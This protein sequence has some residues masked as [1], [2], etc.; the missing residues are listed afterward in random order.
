MLPFA[1]VLTIALEVSGVLK[2]DAPVSVETASI[3]LQ[4]EAL[5]STASQ[6]AGVVVRGADARMIDRLR[7]E[8]SDLKDKAVSDLVRKDSV[9]INRQAA[10]QLK[11]RR[12][13]LVTIVLPA[14]TLTPMGLTPKS[15]SYRV[16]AVVAQ[17]DADTIAPVI[18]LDGSE[19]RDFIGV[20]QRKP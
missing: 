4:A 14:A 2:P 17:S 9:L 11:L 18:Y 13:E 1:L 19:A 6:S 15:K 20:D 3:S 7:F 12:G 8:R 16:A 10:D 5:A